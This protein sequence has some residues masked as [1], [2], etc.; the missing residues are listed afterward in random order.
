MVDPQLVIGEARPMLEEFLTDIGLH[1][2]GF[3]LELRQLL[4]PFST[5]VDAQE[6]NGE[7]RFYLASRLGAFICEYLIE[8]CSAQRVIENGRIVIRLPIQDGISRQF[9]PY[10]VAFRMATNRN[11]LKEFLD[12]LCA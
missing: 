10:A 7:D 2:P 9:E 3:P 12:I 11:S 6:V 1:R 5:W 8:V 4:E